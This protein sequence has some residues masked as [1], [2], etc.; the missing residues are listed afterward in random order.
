MRGVRTTSALGGC[1]LSGAEQVHGG[2]RAG[3]VAADDLVHRLGE[4]QVGDGVVGLLQ[5]GDR[6]LDG[7][8]L[9]RPR[10][11][12][13]AGRDVVVVLGA[14]DQGRRRSSATAPP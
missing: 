14:G 11:H 13:R 1:G 7:L 10:R 5:L 4:Q 12:P 6:R 3:R 2:G 9:A 8:R